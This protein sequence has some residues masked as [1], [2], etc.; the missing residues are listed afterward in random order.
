MPNIV[1]R[2]LLA[3]LLVGAS[4]AQAQTPEPDPDSLTAPSVPDGAERVD[5]SASQVQDLGVLQEELAK[6]EAERQRLADELAGGDAGAMQQLEEENQTL[7]EQQLELDELL[8][9]RREEQRQRWFL[10]GG[11][12][13]AGCLLLGFILGRMGGQKR[14]RE[15]L[16]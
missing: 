13:V 11:G 12:T 6:V 4:A 9:S 2:V 10:I 1:A 16:N 5:Q 8:N 7:R 14:R 3:S 15:W